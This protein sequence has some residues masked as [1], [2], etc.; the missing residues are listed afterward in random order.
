MKSIA[1]A[2][3]KGG[4]GKTTISTHL[5]WR[6]AE[7]GKSVLFIDLDHQGN[8]SSSLSP[9][10]DH[11]GVTASQLFRVDCTIPSPAQ[12]KILLIPGDVHLV[13]ID[14]D[15]AGKNATTSRF[16][17]QVRKQAA[18]YDYLILDVAPAADSRMLAAVLATD[19]LLT[20]IDPETYAIQG[21]QKM[22]ALYQ[23]AEKIKRAPAIGLPPGK[24]LGVA[25]NRLNRNFPSHRENLQSLLEKL[26]TLILP[27]V[28]SLRSAISVSQGARIP[29][30]DVGTSSS[31][32]A[33]KE[34]RKF[35]DSILEKI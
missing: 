7:Q 26:G 27:D 2:N 13:E 17:E 11:V 19:A 34:M 31:R 33:G 4:V 22:Y 16:I 14:D 5:A 28:L 20:P 32:E 12:G 1:I 21:V 35:C 24:F 9:H 30:W 29:V 18:L 15:P 10:S 23:Q 3:Q 6:A 8:A 25:I